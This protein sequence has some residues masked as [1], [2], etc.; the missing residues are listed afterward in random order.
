MPEKKTR[1]K[2]SKRSVKRVVSK[3]RRT[4]QKPSSKVRNYRKAYE[5]CVAKAME[6]CAKRNM[7]IDK[8]SR[9]PKNT[10]SASKKAITKKG[11]NKSVKKPKKVKKVKEDKEIYQDFVSKQ[12][13]D[14][15][16][17]ALNVQDKMKKIGQRWKDLK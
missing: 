14:P 8:K 12:M 3:T 5:A 9:K 1:S 13:K 4:T 7:M 2:V 11:A 10:K 15:E 6:A 16:I 17:K